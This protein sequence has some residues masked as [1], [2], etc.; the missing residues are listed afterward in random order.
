MPISMPASM[1]YPHEE[2]YC[3]YIACS[4]GITRTYSGYYPLYQGVLPITCLYGMGNLYAR[5]MRTF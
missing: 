1:R 2:G 4:E 3:L 5:Y